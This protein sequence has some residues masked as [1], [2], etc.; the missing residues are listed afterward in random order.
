[1]AAARH[2]L[3]LLVRN[4]ELRS[5]LPAEDRE[6]VLKL[7][8]TLRTLE[9]GTY[10]IREA[11]APV[12]CAVLASGFAFRQKLAGDGSRQIV[13][14]HIPGDALDFQN[15]FLDVSDHSIQMLTRAEVAFV[16]IR[17]LQV[18][19]RQRAAVGHAILVKILVEASI[20]R[21][22]VLNVGRRDARTRVVHLLCELGVRLDTEGLATDY[23]YDLPM[24]QEQLADAVGLTSVHVNRTLKSLEAE[25]LIVRSKRSVSFPDWKRLRAAGDFNQRY[26]H[27]EP[28]RSGETV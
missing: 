26:L 18:L 6:A 10:T 1:M 9:A 23:S 12:Q 5:P 22:W 13:A 4:L 28:Q 20:F 3:D 15:L 7:P 24:T 25:G 8:Y 16:A 14:L 21:E 11:D 19:A 27:L 17:D 2:P